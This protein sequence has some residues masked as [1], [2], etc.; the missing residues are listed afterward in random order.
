MLLRVDRQ[1]L[2]AA[3]DVL[4]FTLVKQASGGTA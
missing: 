2:E 4:A 1:A 3:F